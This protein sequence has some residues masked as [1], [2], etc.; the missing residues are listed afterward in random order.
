MSATDHIQQTLGWCWL[1]QVEYHEALAL[2]QRLR[3]EVQDGL[4]GPTLLLLS[5]PPVITLGRSA[6]TGNVLI[7]HQERRR[8]GVKLVRVDRGGDV[9]YHGPGQLVG[10]PIRRVGRAVQRHVKVMTDSLLSALE[11]LDISGR[12][13]DRRPGV[14][15]GGAKI[16]AVGVDARLGVAMHGFALNVDPDLDQ[17][18][19]IVPCGYQAPVTSVAAE[20]GPGGQAPALDDLAAQ[21]AAL[22]A[23][24]YGVGAARQLD[25]QALEPLC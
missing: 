13:D 10:Y 11:G 20:L 4:R 18:G 25:R 19:M 6:G 24:G 23:R 7:S 8:L 22:L 3:R 17:F 12:W 9:T 15:V 21:L 5:H 2:Q 14:W 1:G 16:A